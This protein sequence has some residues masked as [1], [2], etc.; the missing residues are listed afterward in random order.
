MPHRG[1]KVAKP[2]DDKLMLIEPTS[3]GRKP[4]KSAA[5]NA[6]A[7]SNGQVSNGGA[8]G[9][10]NGS[11]T[12]STANISVTDSN[13]TTST[14]VMDRDPAAKG[15]NRTMSRDPTAPPSELAA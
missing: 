8:G 10:Q 5:G 9:V 7:P 15:I 6:V 1:R 11:Y 14:M 13:E 3:L 12:G 4:P 2:L